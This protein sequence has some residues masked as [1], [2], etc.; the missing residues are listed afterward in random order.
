VWQSACNSVSNRID[1]LEICAAENA[2]AEME[3]RF[4][5]L[6]HKEALARKS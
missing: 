6:K 1:I 3:R 5:L 4:S 2:S